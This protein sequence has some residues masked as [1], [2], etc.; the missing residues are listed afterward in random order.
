MADFCVADHFIIGD[1]PIPTPAWFDRTTW[2]MRVGVIGPGL[3]LMQTMERWSCQRLAGRGIFGVCA[4]YDYLGGEP[5][6]AFVVG[7]NYLL[8]PSIRDQKLFHATAKELGDE[9]RVVSAGHQRA[10]CL[11]TAHLYEQARRTWKVAALGYL[12][13]PLARLVDVLLR[14]EPELRKTTTELVSGLYTDD[15]GFVHTGVLRLAIRTPWDGNIEWEA[16]GAHNVFDASWSGPCAGFLSL[17]E[18]S[19]PVRVALRAWPF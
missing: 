2:A 5:C 6:D 12:E 11:R 19:R 8:A 13:D 18:H 17:Q 14:N 3:Q 15:H 16:T 10:L 4:P 9:A 7:C 1:T